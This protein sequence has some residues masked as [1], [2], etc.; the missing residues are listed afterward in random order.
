MAEHD[1]GREETPSDIEFVEVYERGFRQSPEAVGV[2]RDDGQI[3]DINETTERLMQVPRRDA[4]GKTTLELGWWVDPAERDELRRDVED[5]GSA[6]R[7]IHVRRPDGT[8][9]EVEVAVTRVEVSGRMFTFWIGRDVTEHPL[10]EREI[11]SLHDGLRAATVA[12]KRLAIAVTLASDRQR[13]RISDEV[14]ARPIQWLAAA[15]LALETGRD[16]AEGQSLD[17]VRRAVAGAIR[18]LRRITAELRPPVLERDGLLTALRTRLSEFG[19]MY[20][21]D[22]ELDDRL[23]DGRMP[24]DTESFAYRAV[25]EALLAARDRGGV[26]RM[27]V[28]VERPAD[29]VL[30]IELEGDELSDTSFAAGLFADLDAEAELL[31]SLGGALSV[32]ERDGRTI[33]SVRVPAE[34]A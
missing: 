4:I 21:I 13:H 27:R 14:R 2:L 3:V 17:T 29:L 28:T 31:A 19:S 24:A 1:A 16:V 10:S 11:G 5:D 22:V 7:R 25:L 15:L 6:I 26:R 18:D 30:T 9:R 20:G 33:V 8:T 12:R 34:L 23:G 32:S